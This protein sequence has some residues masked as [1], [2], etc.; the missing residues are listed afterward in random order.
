MIYSKIKKHF[1][2]ILSRLDQTRV[3]KLM[4]TKNHRTL[5]NIVDAFLEIKHALHTEEDLQLFQD[6]ENYRT[7][8]LKNNN[9]IFHE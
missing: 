1:S 3:L 2:I 4:N 8:L 9:L 7:Q 5:N 6:C